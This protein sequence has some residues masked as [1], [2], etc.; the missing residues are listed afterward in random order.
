M[1]ILELIQRKYSWPLQ[2]N[3]SQYLTKPCMR[4]TLQLHEQNLHHC[5]IAEAQKLRKFQEIIPRVSVARGK[6]EKPIAYTAWSLLNVIRVNIST[7][8][9]SSNYWSSHPSPSRRINSKG[10]LDQPYVASNHVRSPL[11]KIRKQY[12]TLSSIQLSFVFKTEP[13][14][15]PSV[16]FS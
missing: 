5:I 1:Y 14:Q 12:T 4:I 11:E 9:F 6:P 8:K 16:D 7:W 10:K 15:I 3:H 2:I 13:Y